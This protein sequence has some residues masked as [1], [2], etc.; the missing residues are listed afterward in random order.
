MAMVYI[1]RRDRH[2]PLGRESSVRFAAGRE[3]AV[4]YLSAGIRLALGWIFPWAFLDKTFGLG[5]DTPRTAS[6]VN[7][8]SPTKG[9]PGSA[10]K[11]PFTGLYHAL[12]AVGA[13]VTLLMWTVVLPPA[14]NPFL[15]DHVVYAA[16]LVLLALMNAGDSL[17]LDRPWASTAVVRRA[18]WLR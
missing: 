8:G 3:D 1:T 7:G 18:G 9:F 5:H 6:W 13:L 4:R 10:A 15:D 2:G 12:A 16:V 14:S 17:G 11:G